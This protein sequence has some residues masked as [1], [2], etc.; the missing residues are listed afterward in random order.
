MGTGNGAMVLCAQT[1]ME[2]ALDLMGVDLLEGN[3]DD[4]AVGQGPYWHSHFSDERSAMES[5]GVRLPSWR[6]LVASSYHTDSHM[7]FP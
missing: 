3:L 5:N 6:S 4:W 7:G 1:S 2:Q